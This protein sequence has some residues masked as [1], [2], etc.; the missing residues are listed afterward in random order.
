M[1]IDTEKLRALLAAATP[2]PWRAGTV[3]TWNVYAD[4]N[5]DV[6]APGLGRVVAQMNR[7]YPHSNDAALI[8]AAVNALPELLDALEAA[9][10]KRLTLARASAG[11]TRTC[12]A[13]A[14]K[15]G[16]AASRPR[17]RGL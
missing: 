7:H 17:P 4:P 13:C 3:E 1:T 10:A 6:M 5:G 9:E 12:K 11:S 16:P 14:T 8:A 2:G 15:S